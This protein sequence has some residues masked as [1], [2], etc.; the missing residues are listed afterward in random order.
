MDKFSLRKNSAIE[1][2]ALI[3]GGIV[4]LITAYYL[5]TA[6]FAVTIFDRAPDPATRPDWRLLGCSAGGGDSRIFSLNESRHHL[7]NSRHYE[8]ASGSPFRRTIEEN[9]WLAISPTTL[10]W[11]D[12]EWIK[13]FESVPQKLA[14]Q[15]NSDII[16]FNRESEPLWRD[17]IASHPSLFERSG[18]QRGL[19]RLYA[20]EDKY[21]RA[22][23]SERAIGALKRELSQ[24]DLATELPVLQDAIDANSIRGS[25]EVSGFSVNIHALIGHLT[26]YLSSSGVRFCWNTRV[27]AVI[28]DNMGHVQGLRIGSNTIESKHFVLSIGAY[29]RH[30]LEGFES[31]QTIAPVIGMWLTLPDVSPFLD[32]PLKITR[33]GFAAN[34]AAEGANV[35]SGVDSE[36]RAV[37][38]VSSGH[39]YIGIGNENRLYQDSFGLRRAV[40]E[41]AKAF[42]PRQYAAGFHSSDGISNSRTCVRPWTA[43]GLGIFESLETSHHGSFVVTGGHNTGGFAQAP[44]I[45]MATLALLQRRSHPMHTLYHP[46]RLENLLLDVASAHAPQASQGGRR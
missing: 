17:F 40:E 10:G 19:V 41:T 26:K 39:G 38:H 11:A 43:S 45:A 46:M 18:L 7:A 16:S 8:D 34:G 36:G 32:R 31:A 20:A 29:S 6:G 13:R 22:L 12:L 37:I 30:L 15:F 35:V 5:T 21:R 14:A 1:T 9:G 24:H 42:F 3:G 4:N 28:R 23:D 44:A 27:D 2:V 33:V 25:I